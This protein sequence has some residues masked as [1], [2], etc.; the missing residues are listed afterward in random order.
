MYG[1]IVH[2][3]KK[4]VN[5]QYLAIN[6]DYVLDITNCDWCKFD[7]PAVCSACYSKLLEARK[8]IKE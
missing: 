7:Y 8:K 6:D 4:E 2:N 3:S 5:K 1:D